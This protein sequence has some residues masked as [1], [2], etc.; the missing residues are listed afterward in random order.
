MNSEAEI[1][2][3]ELVYGARRRE[4]MWQKLGLTGM[5][6]GMAGCLT[7]AL[8]SIIQAAL[9]WHFAIIDSIL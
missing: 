5:A 9:L 3:E 2:E 1:I 7:A 8:A 6:F 4:L